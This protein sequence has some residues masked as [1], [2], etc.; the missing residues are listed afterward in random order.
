MC[1]ISFYG[2]AE[3]FAEWKG[4]GGGV[5]TKASHGLHSRNIPSEGCGGLVLLFRPSPFLIVGTFF[6]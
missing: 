2:L 5:R 1:H 3:C 6:W 4:G